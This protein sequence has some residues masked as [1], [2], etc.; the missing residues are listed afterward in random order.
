MRLTPVAVLA[1]I[2]L[3]LAFAL[4]TASAHDYCVAK[5][6]CA[7]TV[8]VAANLQ[9]QLTAAETNGETDR[10]FLGSVVFARGPYHY[11][12]AEPV[13]LRGSR[14]GNNTISTFQS[15][16]VDRTA[17]TLT[18]PAISLDGVRIDIAL[19]GS[20]GLSLASGSARGISIVQQPGTSAGA[21]VILSDG[22]TLA[23]S[24]IDVLPDSAPGAGLSS[25]SATITGTRI[26]GAYG[27]LTVPGAD[28]LTVARSTLTASVGA[29]AYGGTIRLSDTVVDG[30]N[31]RISAAFFA[32]AQSG[33]APT[34]EATRTTVVGNDATSTNAIGAYAASSGGTATV[35]VRDSAMTGVGVPALRVT[36]PGGVGSVTLDRVAHG[37]AIGNADRGE[38]TTTETNR[39]PA[40]TGFVDP[41]DSNFRLLPGSSL[42]D[43]GDPAYAGAADATDRDGQPRLRDGDGDCTARVDVGAYEYQPTG[44]CTPPQ[45]PTVDPPAPGTPQPQPQPQPQPRTAPDRT[46]PR[47]SAVR[48]PARLTPGAALP[49]LRAG[50]RASAI[51]FTLSER[52]SVTLRFK[53][54]GRDGR[55]RAVRG[56]AATLKVSAAAGPNRLRFAGRVT[57]RARLTSGRYRVTLVAT[58]AAGNRSRA[59]SA[60]FRIG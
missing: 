33:F 36:E 10:F 51:A 17:L 60:P 19:S 49:R 56:P 22:A 15:A 8:V 16:V 1:S 9:A 52:A 48:V 46:A 47:L 44:P 27:V 54:R 14:G 3:P 55:Y 32:L 30:R 20:A 59:V 26:A 34:V 50:R 39:L 13:E 37:D 2:T 6:R 7:G 53:R 45:P 41:S 25:G 58:D 4:P 5:P 21:G 12:S 38:G 40:P 18:G 43:V 42:I 11:Q 57:R 28:T 35:T 31:Q 24:T 23:D 29:F